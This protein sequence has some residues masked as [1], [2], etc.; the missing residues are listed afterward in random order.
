MYIC[1]ARCDTGVSECTYVARCDTGVSEC[2]V[3][4][5]CSVSKCANMS[6]GDVHRRRCKVLSGGACI[7]SESSTQA[8]HYL[9]RPQAREVLSSSL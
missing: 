1:D 8:R 2:A 6:P 7:S 3:V 5:K 4:T 9:Q